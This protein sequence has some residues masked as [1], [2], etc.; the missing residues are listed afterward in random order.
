MLGF[1]RR[2]A[3]AAWTV[4]LVALLL[5]VLYS[6]RSVLLVFVLAILF[7]YML[8]PIVNLVNRMLPWPRSRAYSLAAVYTALVGLLIL[9]GVLV[10]NRVAQEASN[11]A[12]GFPKLQESVVRRLQEPWPAWFEPLRQQ[13][14]ERA[15]NI[16]PLLAPLVQQAGSQVLSVLGRIVYVV[17]IPVLSF[18]FLKDG[19]ELLEQALA[20]VKPKHRAMWNEIAADMHVLLGRFIRALALLALAT[21][22]AYGIFFTAIGLPY[23]LLLATIAGMLEFIPLFGPVAAV[24]IV[25]LVAVVSGF[26]HFWSI[27]AALVAYRMFQDYF[28]NPHLIGA[29]V[30]LH[31]LLVILG[32]L[33]GGEVAGVPG[34]F[35]SVP[36]MATLRVIYIRVRKAREMAT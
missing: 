1:D 9:A 17:L 13:I 18:L 15:Q 12:N 5:A 3:R 16:A 28:L 30:A 4:F 20:L 24:A 33:A 11:L 34:M 2:A 21:T 26:G 27:L 29:G 36:A 19:K 6:I 14:R 32:A 35:L 10:G 22:T 8:S 7:A 23:S 31:P 25:V